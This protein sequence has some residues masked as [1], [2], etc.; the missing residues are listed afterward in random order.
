MKKEEYVETVVFRDRCIP[1]GIED[2]GQTYFIEYV[3]EQGEFVEDCCGS[4]NTD[5]NG[6]IEYRFGEPDR[7][8]PYYDNIDLVM[9]PELN[10]EHRFEFGYC[11]KCKYQDR[12]WT[13]FQELVKLN[14]IDRRGTV[15]SPYDKFLKM[16]EEE[17]KKQ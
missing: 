5:Y 16:I 6:Y 10:C 7:D 12:K 1:V 2:A 17:D 11:D 13:A 9:D 8:C 15:L 4:Y 3:N 14:I